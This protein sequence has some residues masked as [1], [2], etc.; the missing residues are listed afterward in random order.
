MS[1]DKIILGTVQLGKKYGINNQNNTMPSREVAFEVLETAYQRGIR[2]FDTADNYGLSKDYLKEFLKKYSDVYILTKGEIGE[3]FI[4]S[5]KNSLD[6]IP[7][8]NVYCFSLH[9]FE[10][11]KQF[12][13]KKLLDLKKE[14]GLL[15]L[16]ISVYTNEELEIAINFKSIDVI[17]LPF[18]LID[19]W[20]LRGSLLEK[21]YQFKK[22]IHVRSVFLQGLLLSNLTE[23]DNR[24]SAL[25]SHIVKLKE[26]ANQEKL[27]LGSLALLYPMNFKEISKVLI[28]VDNGI[29]LEDNL[30]FTKIELS[31]ESIEKINNLV[32]T[33][34]DLLNPRNW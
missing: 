16:G 32:F 3:D 27:S 25:A 21:A 28:G 19:N 34:T 22:E 17:Q 12:N 6:G 29:Q 8:K 9:R 30:K 13:D 7:V 24:F 31:K 33:N 10:D 4:S 15:R 2:M 20:A 26:I 11:I 14:T 18:N 5:V 23:V 1:I